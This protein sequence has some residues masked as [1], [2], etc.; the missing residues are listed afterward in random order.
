MDE[1]RGRHCDPLPIDASH[2]ALD[3]NAMSDAKRIVFLHHG[4]F[5]FGN[6]DLGKVRMRYFSGGIEPALTKLGCTVFSTQVHPTAGIEQ[7]ARELKS[8]ILLRTRTLGQRNARVTIIG[9]SM[10]GLDARHMIAHLGMADRVEALVTISTPH[11]GSPYADWVF[12]NLGTKL[13]GADLIRTLGIELRALADLRIDAMR[14]FNDQTPDE[15]AVNYFSIATFQ[16]PSRIAPFLLPCHKIVFAREGEN[17]GVVSVKS[18]IWGTHLETWQTDHLHAV[19]RR[20]T[21]RTMMKSGDVSE[22]YSKLI[23]RINGSAA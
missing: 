16:T 7:R 4:L 12:D 1:S 14:V 23:E 22:R 9:H 13:R 2:P 6:F 11:R 17:D 21:P 8:Q 18:A 20:F 10:G 15:V 3:S 5:G 19:N